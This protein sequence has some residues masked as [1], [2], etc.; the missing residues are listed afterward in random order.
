MRHSRLCLAAIFLLCSSLVVAQHSSGSSAGSSSNSSGGGGSH[1]SSSAGSSSGASGGGAHS[2]G[3]SSGGGHS[4]S[5]DN[6]GG[7]NSAASGH[8]STS[9]GHVSAGSSRDGRAQGSASRSSGERG[10]TAHLSQSFATTHSE[11]KDIRTSVIRA[12]REPILG[13]QTRPALPERRGFFSFL[14]HPFRRPQPKLP[15]TDLRHHL[16]LEGPCEVCPNGQLAAKGGCGGMIAHKS[17]NAC[18]AAELWN[19]SMCIAE[20]R[21]VDDCSAYARMM[22]RQTQRMQAAESFRQSACANGTAQECSEATNSWQSESNLYRTLQ[23]QYQRCLLRSGR[24]AHSIGT[25]RLR[26]YDWN[27]WADPLVPDWTVTGQLW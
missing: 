14:R 9:S 15:V 10:T 21:V 11:Q 7:H 20:L 23:V 13:P 24:T 17:Y 12:R 3:G 2:S 1:S 25:F 16:C 5:A 22:Q 26:S 8:V 4:A 19:G 6:T 18:P 27:S